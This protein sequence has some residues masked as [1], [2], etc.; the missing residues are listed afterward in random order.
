MTLFRMRYALLILGLIISVANVT[1][2]RELT[3][4]DAI[5]VSLR[6]SPELLKSQSEKNEAEAIF[7]KYKGGLFPEI[8]LRASAEA[9][10]NSARVV[11]EVNDLDST[12]TYTAA[13]DVTQPLFSG[14][15][16]LGGLRLGRALT[17]G[18]E[19][20]L[21]ITRQAVVRQVVEAFYNLAEAQN[22]LVAAQENHQILESYAKITSRYE[23]IG[24]TREIDRIQSGINLSLGQIDI[25]D[26]EQKRAQAE[27]NIKKLLSLESEQEIKPNFTISVQSL[28]TISVDEAVATAEKNNPEIRGAR[29]KLDEVKAQN[30][31]DL[32]TDLPSL[33]LTG[34]TGYKSPDRDDIIADNTDFYT[35]GLTL[36]VPLFS[37]LSSVAKRREHHENYY[38]AER[39][40]Q[41]KR[42]NVRE[43]I[44]STLNNARNLYAQVL[45]LQ[46]VVKRSRRALDLANTGY[47][48]GIVSSQDIIQ[49]QR[50]RYESEKL[51][52]KTQYNYLR[53]VLVVRELLG[54]DLQRVYAQ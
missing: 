32:S 7:A 6:T 37:G 5:A 17:D 19:Q 28:A 1:S 36:K 9:S 35:V 48:R 50:S 23:K 31:I 41:I 30:Q 51:F 10:K 22:S 53:S 4:Q 33:S 16:M 47:N 44:D 12:K 38:Q 13:L 2:A 39:D 15:K 14:G 21:F 8:S 20:K 26:A 3:L 46:D 29:L 11:D 40:M 43:E 49:F 54:T 18:A 52:V 25:Q 42:Q 27:A 34:S 24:R 45:S